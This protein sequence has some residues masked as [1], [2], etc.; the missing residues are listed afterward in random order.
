MPK[1]NITQSIQSLRKKI[2]RRKTEEQRL[3]DLIGPFA[4]HMEMMLADPL[5]RDHPLVRS[6]SKGKTTYKQGTKQVEELPEQSFFKRKS[7]EQMKKF[8]EQMKKLQEQEQE[9]RRLENLLRQREKEEREKASLVLLGSSI[10][11]NPREFA[12]GGMYKGK[13]HMYAAGGRV[14]DTRNIKRSK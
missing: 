9:R 10:K 11:R 8:Q 12:A 5:Y 3:R 7:P 4:P 14:T 13:K 6:L 1:L 2:Q